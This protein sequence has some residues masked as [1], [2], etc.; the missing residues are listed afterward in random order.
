M[1]G[2][3]TA[4]ALALALDQQI[5]S[6]IE[7]EYANLNEN[8]WWEHVAQRATSLSKSE[9]I[10]W[11]LSTAK[12][13]RP[14]AAHGGGQSAFEDLVG[15]YTEFENLNAFSGLRLKKEQM[16]DLFNGVPGGEAMDAA[17]KWARDVA[18]YAVYWPQEVVSD[19]MKAN[20]VAYDGV[21]FFANN[22]PVNPFDTGAGT[23]ANHFTGAAAGAYPGALPIGTSV[24]LDVAQANLIKARNYIASI[25]H[26]NGKTPR[27]LRVAKIITPPALYPRA[28]QLTEARFI[29]GSSS[30]PNDVTGVVRA[31]GLGEPVEAHELGANFGGSDTDYYLACEEIGT[32]QLGAFAYVE[33]ESFGVQMHSGA[34]SAE[35]ARKREFQ[36]TLE[37]RNVVAPGHPYLLFKCS[38]T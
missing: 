16:E 8:L 32:S 24:A 37:G 12:I 1:P 19:A 34:T 10:H 26:P 15:L 11:L 18:K 25:K 14:N 2:I 7:N 29:S 27:R 21:A 4:G 38:A 23:Y 9:R 33:R 6:I 17:A 5:R 22:H 3:V 30:G 31:L 28:V 36:W 13:E 35:L 20:S